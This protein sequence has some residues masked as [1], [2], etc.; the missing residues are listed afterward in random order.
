MVKEASSRVSVLFVVIYWD[1]E[2]SVNLSN[3]AQARLLTSGAG[4]WKKKER[5]F[6][7]AWFGQ[8]QKN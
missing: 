2:V 7:C 8:W 4:I 6:V 3:V 1:S 5:E